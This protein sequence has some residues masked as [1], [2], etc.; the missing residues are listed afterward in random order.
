VS[1]ARSLLKAVVDCYALA[2]ALLCNFCHMM[3][4]GEVSTSLSRDDC[5][6]S[7][8]CDEHQTVTSDAVWCVCV[9]LPYLRVSKQGSALA[10]EAQLSH[11]YSINDWR[12]P[13]MHK[14]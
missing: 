5:E 3:H 13:D 9:G 12:K 7:G 2:L 6:L 4:A 11:G 10:A 1:T 8:R 14:L